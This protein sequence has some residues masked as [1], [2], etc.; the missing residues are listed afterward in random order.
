[1]RRK[2][3]DE[4]YLKISFIKNEA[5]VSEICTDCPFWALSLNFDHGRVVFDLTY[6][7]LS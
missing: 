4:L 1:V 6:N 3:G 5:A 7:K 2:I